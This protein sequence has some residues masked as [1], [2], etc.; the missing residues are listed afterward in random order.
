MSEIFFTS[1]PHLCHDR[2]FIYKARGFNSIKEHDETIISNWNEMIA[3]D[4]TI[5]MFGDLM[6]GTDRSGGLEKLSRLNG[7]IILT[8][9]NHDTDS[10]FNDYLTC[11]NVCAELSARD[12][13]SK[14]IKVGK[15]SFL[16]CHWSTMVGDT[17][18]GMH[19]HKFFCLHGHTHSKDRFQ[20]FEHGCYNV[21]MDAHNCRPVN[22]KEI[23]SDIIQ[24]MEEMR[25]KSV[26]KGIAE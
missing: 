16:G 23:Q 15:W 11:D 26:E 25:K 17:L 24:K 2:D 5:Y 6:M 19:G 14:M 12:V 21:A 4:D 7:H 13:F 9:G 20:F 3:P 10:K 8:R 18:H 1:D 22:V